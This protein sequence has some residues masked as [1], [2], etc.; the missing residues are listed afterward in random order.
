MITKQPDPR[1]SS[2]HLPAPLR[3]PLTLA[4]VSDL[5]DRDN[6]PVLA[7]LEQAAPE[8]VLV[9]GDF[10]HDYRRFRR[11]LS[12]LEA[13]AGRWPTFCSIGNHELLFDGDLKAAVA[14]T[15]A[16]LLDNEAISFCGI[17]IGGLSSGLHEQK[18]LRYFTTRQKPDCEFLRRFARQPGYKLLLCHHPEYFDPYIRPLAIDLT[19]SGHAHGGQWR[20]F[21]RGAYAPGQGIFPRYTSGLY[22]RGRLLVGRGLGNATRIPR[23]N[24]PPEVLKITLEPI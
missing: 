3:S 11:G 24:N 2:Y 13:C 12:F 21:G 22:R 23:I 10:I 4:F 16:V 15:G 8:A 5:H 18:N 6:E 19:L 9:G 7:A 1:I 14:R 20:L 17:R